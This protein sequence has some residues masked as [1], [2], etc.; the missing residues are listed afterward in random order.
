MA[1]DNLTLEQYLNEEWAKAWANAEEPT[2]EIFGDSE[3]LPDD[4]I[5]L[6]FSAAFCKLT[7]PAKIQAL[8]E[9]RGAKGVLPN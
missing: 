6:I 4:E 8:A 3:T 1:N 7:Q 9:L 5:E 2:R